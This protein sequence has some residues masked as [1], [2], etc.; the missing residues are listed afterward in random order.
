M[1]HLYITTD[2][3]EKVTHFFY[4]EEVNVTM[5]RSCKGVIF[6]VFSGTYRLRSHVWAYFLRNQLIIFARPLPRPLPT[7]LEIL[8]RIP[9]RFLASSVT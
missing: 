9:K 1:I 3:R 6:E 7:F 2:L 4:M 5:T 8:I